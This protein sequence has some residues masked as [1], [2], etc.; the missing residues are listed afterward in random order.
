MPASS[1][2]SRRS[3]YPGGAAGRH[4]VPAPLGA[5]RLRGRRRHLCRAGAA[6]RAIS[7]PGGRRRRSG[8]WC[9]PTGRAS[10][11]ADLAACLPDF[12]VAAIREALPAFGRQI[13]GFAMADAVHD[14]RGDPHLVADAHHPRRGLPEPEHRAGCIRPARARA[15]PAASCRRGWTA[16]GSPRRWRSAW[17]AR[18]WSGEDRQ[19]RLGDGVGIGDVVA[20]EAGSARGVGR[21]VA[22]GG[23]ARCPCGSVR[24]T[25]DRGSPAGRC[26]GS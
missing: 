4:R 18:L 8:R 16:S 10:T 20:E 2:A 15:M 5:A 7:W 3:D 11:P 1:S 6:G 13:P 9:R 14:R 21:Y 26:R 23:G 17:P 24:R 19:Q 25:R 22:D 12:A